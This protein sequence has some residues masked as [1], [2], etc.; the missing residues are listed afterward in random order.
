V[1]RLPTQGIEILSLGQEKHSGSGQ[2]PKKPRVTTLMWA[3]ALPKT[4]RLLTRHFFRRFIENDQISPDADRH[5]TLA[6][7][8]ACLIS[9]GL[10]VTML[11]AIKYLAGV[12]IPGQTALTSLDDKFLYIGWSMLMMGLVALAEWDALALDV[13]DA[14]I[15]GPLPIPG[16]VC[17]SSFTPK[18]R[19]CSYSPGPVSW[20]SMRCQASSFRLRWS[21]NSSLARSRM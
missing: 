20:C 15:L 4:T 18:P 13:R 9:F 8:C 17:A 2:T 11:L 6:V 21:R 5:Q 14:S 19:R 12:P 1:K 10:V 3:R 7:G 16:R